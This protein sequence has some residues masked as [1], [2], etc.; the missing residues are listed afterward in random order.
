MKLLLKIIIRI[1]II[2]LVL[3]SLA[4]GYVM[5]KNPMGLG[6]MIKRYVNGEKINIEEAQSYDHPLLNEEQ[7]TRLINAGVDITQ[8]PESITPEQEKCVTDKISPERI[9]EIIDGA[10]PTPFEIIQV[11]PCL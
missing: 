4:L 7:E 1:F 9:Q 5:I 10:Q 8:V 2:L 11:L 3:I 6:D